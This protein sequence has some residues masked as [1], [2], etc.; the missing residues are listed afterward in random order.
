VRHLIVRLV[1]ASKT[2]M[3]QVEEW[4]IAFAAEP[5]DLDAG[6]L[7]A[8]YLEHEECTVEQMLAGCTVT[9]GRKEILERLASVVPDDPEVATQLERTPTVVTT[10]T[11]GWSPLSISDGESPLDE[12]QGV[13]RTGDPVTQQF[14]PG[15]RVGVGV[16]VRGDVRRSVVMGATTM[17]RISSIASVLA[18]VDWTQREGDMKQVDAIAASAGIAARVFTN[19]H[20]M[21]AIGVAG[22][23]E[24]RLG[25]DMSRPLGFAGDLSIDLVS[26]KTP[27]G[28]GLRLEKQLGDSATLA[29]IELALEL[30]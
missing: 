22:R 2:R 5:P 4:R 28:I 11:T 12:N 18:R 21:L 27:L 30:R 23:S 6:Y 14:R 13:T 24:Y 16:G 20:A 1:L 9:G 3:E 8:E 29:T 19:R 26:R 25:E 10:Q 15:L 17:F 7:L